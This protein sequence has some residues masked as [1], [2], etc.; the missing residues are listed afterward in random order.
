MGLP[1]ALY[2]KGI[3]HFAEQGNPQQLGPLCFGKV[4]KKNAK[5]VVAEEET[6]TTQ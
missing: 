2:P 3:Q 4:L 6:T 5:G 1:S